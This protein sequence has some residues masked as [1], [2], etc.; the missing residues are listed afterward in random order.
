MITAVSLIILFIFVIA[1][2][3]VIVVVKKKNCFPKTLGTPNKKTPSENKKTPA[4]EQGS[5]NVKQ[6]IL[7]HLYAHYFLNIIWQ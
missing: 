3:V 2:I 1:I 4:Q 5:F 7:L 6:I